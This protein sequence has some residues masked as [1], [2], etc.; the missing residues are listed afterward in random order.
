MTDLIQFVAVGLAGWRVAS[1]LVQEDGPFEIFARLRRA[2]GLERVGE[3]PS[4]FLPDLLSCVWCASVWTTLVAYGAWRAGAEG[5]V[6]VVA[7][8]AVAV[9]AQRASGA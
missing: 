8:M 6:L 1:L 4:G 5:L 3:L 7:A 2:V 9:L